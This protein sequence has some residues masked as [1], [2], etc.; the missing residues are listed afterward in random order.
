MTADDSTTEGAPTGRP[1]RV[2]CVCEGNLCRS[3]VAQLL[4]SDALDG[5]AEVTSAGTRAVVGAPVEPPMPDL[6]SARGISSEGFRARQLRPAQLREA[7]L[8]LTMT[9]VQR[10]AAVALAPAV[11]RRTFTLRELA[12]LLSDGDPVRLDGDDVAAR[13]RQVV[14]AAAA[15]K[16][17]RADPDA[18]DVA[19]P[20][21]RPDAAFRR[22][23]GEIADAVDRIGA[24]VQGTGTVQ[25]TA[26]RPAEQ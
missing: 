12:R 13:L 18:D 15:R 1:F 16:R 7:D 21:G 11:V 9:A 14:P 2:L 25:P 5:V 26:D 8:V 6:L 17:Y 19:D 10:A 23:F 4:L 20:Y 3:P 24:V 22:A